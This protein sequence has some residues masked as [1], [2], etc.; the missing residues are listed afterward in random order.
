MKQ[1]SLLITTARAYSLGREKGEGYYAD[2]HIYPTCL[3]IDKGLNQDNRPENLVR[4]THAEHYEAHKLLHLL[5]PEHNGLA[6]AF[7]LMSHQNG[8][9][10]DAK[11]YAGAQEIV[12]AQ[13]SVL[14]KDLNSSPEFQTK[15]LAGLKKYFY[16]NSTEVS[17]RT[18]KRNTEL[19]AKG[20]HSSQKPE[21]RLALSERQKDLAAKGLHVSQSNKFKAELSER[22]KS[23]SSAGQNLFQD[24]DILQCKHC[25]ICVDYS[26][27]GKHHGDRCESL[28]SYVIAVHLATSET[29]KFRTLRLAIDFTGA[30]DARKVVSGAMLQCKGW[31]FTR[32]SR[33]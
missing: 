18:A 12:S 29:Y 4:L 28:T 31:Y 15:R 8:V 9:E 17:E 1:Y 3:R 27:H 19:A 22:M 14:I 2:H 5:Y 7:F 23:L 10:V 16:D 20:L 26:N 32:L 13:S 11:V 21:N 24:R 25:G 6:T 30:Y 33:Q